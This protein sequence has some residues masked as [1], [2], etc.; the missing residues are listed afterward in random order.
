MGDG[1]A[2]IAAQGI[3]IVGVSV[4]FIDNRASWRIDFATNATDQQRAQAAALIE[5]FNPEVNIT[6][7]ETDRAA[8]TPAQVAALLNRI[9]ARQAQI[10]QRRT[11]I[12]ADLAL[13]PTATAAQQRQII[14]RLLNSEDDTLT[15]EKQELTALDRL[16]RAM[17]RLV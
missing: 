10:D 11:A 9:D 15:A 17:R 1:V 12:A 2:A 8:V 5:T 14:G 16:I 7:D 6:S 4:R 3:P 13:L